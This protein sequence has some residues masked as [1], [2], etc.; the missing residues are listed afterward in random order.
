MRVVSDWTPGQS[1]ARLEV[2]GELLVL[3]VDRI[4]G[5]YRVR[6]R[7]A[8]LAVTRAFAADGGAGAR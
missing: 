4:T 5:G 8:D 2:D 7:G 1:L 6:V 3:K